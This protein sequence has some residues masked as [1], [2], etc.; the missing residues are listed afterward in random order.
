MR[1][2]EFGI[3]AVAIGIDGWVSANPV[4]A[5]AIGLLDKDTEPERLPAA[6]RTVAGSR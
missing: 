5:G 4:T 6:P 2:G 3:R 1:A